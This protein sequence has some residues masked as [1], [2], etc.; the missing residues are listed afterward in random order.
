MTIEKYKAIRNSGR[1]FADKIINVKK[2][3]KE[4][5]IYAGKS[6]GLWKDQKLV[7]DSEEESDV[8]MDFL[9]FEKG[10]D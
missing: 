1:N 9:V 2:L 3:N 4:N 5:L 7:F 6:L 8:L 10:K